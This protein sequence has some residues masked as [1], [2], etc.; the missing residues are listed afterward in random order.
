MAI[1]N[2]ELKL[3]NKSD[4]KS[5]ILESGTLKYIDSMIKSFG[6]EESLKSA[7]EFAT[8][9]S[10]LSPFELQKSKIVLYYIKNN[11]ELSNYLSFS[12]I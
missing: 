10:F 1:A 7:E 4:S 9:I 11:D 12:S 8:K 3:G 6:N 2:I 5:I